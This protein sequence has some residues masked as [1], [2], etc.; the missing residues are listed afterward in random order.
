M[1]KPLAI[2]VGEP[3]GI[4]PDV[5]LLAA[6]KAWPEPLIAIADPTLLAERA[7]L[8]GLTLQLHAINL[9]AIGQ[10]S[11]LA[12]GNL[13]V[14]PVALR[15][16]VIAG[17]LNIK[18]AAYVLESLSLAA[19]LALENAVRAIVTAP[20]HK[21]I[22]NDAGVTFLGHTEFF[23]QYA[24]VKKTVMLFVT[25][26]TKI[27][28]A[29][30]HIPLNQV[31]S[32]ITQASLMQTLQILLSGLQTQFR[33]AKPCILVC[34]LNP[35]AGEQGH[36]GREEI[37]TITP[38]INTLQAQGVNIQGPYAADTIFLAEHLSRCDAILGMYHDQVLPVVKTM[39]FERTVNVT[40]GLPFVRTSVD[41]G[42]ALDKAGGKGLVQA[43]SMQAAMELALQLSA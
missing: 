24:N 29:T 37:E 32:S 43:S 25:D 21:G 31:S 35:H 13:Y 20:V 34:G 9:A 26:K 16:P 11:P 14:L 30:T 17:Q 22:L 2:S 42:T 38:V 18:N 40:L 6:Q 12:A 5:T 19:K 33:I 41:H 10:L 28:L 8:L 27:A 1:P 39:A 4:G 7:Q 36:L 3:A 23:A 15:A